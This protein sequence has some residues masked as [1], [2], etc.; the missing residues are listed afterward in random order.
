MNQKKKKIKYR[1][2]E[3]KKRATNLAE[4]VSE[5]III[6]NNNDGIFIILALLIIQI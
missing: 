4:I 5:T 3:T 6:I 2:Q 1:N